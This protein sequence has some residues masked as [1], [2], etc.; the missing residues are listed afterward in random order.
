MIRKVSKKMCYFANYFRYMTKI[1][2]FLV[3]F[4]TFSAANLV[5]RAEVYPV[6]SVA[7]VG[8]SVRPGFITRIIDY[9]NESNK[10]EPGRHLDF[11]IIGGPH[12]SSDSKLGIGLLAAGVYTVAPGDTLTSPSNFSIFGDATT[13][14]HF[15]L[16]VRGDHFSLRNSWWLSYELRFASI[17]TKFWCIGYDQCRL[18]DNETEFR[19]LELSSYFIAAK[20]FGKYLYFGPEAVVSY[21]K[22][23]KLFDGGR[24]TYLPEHTVSPGVGFSLTYDTRDNI[25]NPQRGVML[26]VA[27]IFCPKFL[28]NTSGYSYNELTVAG[29]Q[30]LWRGCTAAAQFHWRLA[31]N[32]VPWTQLSGIGGS[33]NMRGYFE[34]RYRDCC[35]ADV[36]LELRQKVWRRV[37]VVAWVGA[38]RIFDKPENFNLKHVLPNYGF[39]YRWEFK[40]NMNVRIDMGFGR[41]Q[42]GV[43]FNINEAF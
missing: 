42:S 2:R 25:T 6:D 33:Y 30:H 27:Q 28:G 11:S 41:G 8:D 32:N 18:D 31:W 40:K 14:A 39:G 36:C 20:R 1:L 15:K 16:G 5:A 3:V 22:A 17:D 7:A 19:Y 24:W 26:N 9:F 12:Y 21:V 13:A 34:D 23:D 43:V 29:Y 35:E 10:Q 4:I 37:G 38:A